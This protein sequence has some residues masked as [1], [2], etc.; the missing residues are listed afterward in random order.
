M[1]KKVFVILG[2][3]LFLL[4]ALSGCSQK[5]PI[6]SVSTEDPLLAELP[7][8]FEAA[9]LNYARIEADHATYS[10]LNSVR[11]TRE[12]LQEIS[13]A[14]FAGNPEPLEPPERSVSGNIKSIIIQFP[15]EDK[16]HIIIEMFGNTD[17]KTD[18]TVMWLQ[19]G[20][21]YAQYTLESSAFDKIHELVAANTHPKELLLKE[22][23]SV[24]FPKAW[25][26]MKHTPTWKTCWKSAAGCYFYGAI[27]TI[28]GWMP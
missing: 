23:M 6:V 12:L 18:R 8:A 21:D 11:V 26:R 19:V 14:L 3:G 20:E 24:M 1:M 17:E 4:L 15:I 13:D 25:I 5:E 16:Q 27:R 22:I 10:D 9:D 2:I 28:T 7:E